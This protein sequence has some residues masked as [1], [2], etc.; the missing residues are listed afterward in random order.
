MSFY[1]GIVT[2]CHFDWVNPRSKTL[3][4]NAEAAFTVA[5]VVWEITFFLARAEFVISYYLIE[6]SCLMYY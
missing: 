5:I 2:F 6:L 3:L 1:L 4:S